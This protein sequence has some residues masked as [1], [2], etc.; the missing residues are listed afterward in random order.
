V[1]FGKEREQ[2]AILLGGGTRQRQQN[3][4]KHALERRQGYEQSKKQYTEKGEE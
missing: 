2:T 1:Y 3:D 4:I